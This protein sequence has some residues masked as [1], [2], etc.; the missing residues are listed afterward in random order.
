MEILLWLLQLPLLLVLKMEL[1]LAYLLSG[2]Q[3]PLELHLIYG[4]SSAA[5]HQLDLSSF[6]NVKDGIPRN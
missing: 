3:F 1:E 4:L 5:Y 2:K 6:L